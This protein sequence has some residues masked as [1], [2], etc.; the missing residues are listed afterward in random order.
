MF[1]NFYFQ[2]P[3]TAAGSWFALSQSPGVVGTAVTTKGAVGAVTEA[4]N[5]AASSMFSSCEEE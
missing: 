5:Y 1:M 2:T 4:I 3:F